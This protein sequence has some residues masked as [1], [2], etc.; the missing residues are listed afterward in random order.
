PPGSGDLAWLAIKNGFSSTDKATALYHDAKALDEGK[1]TPDRL[2]LDR[3]WPGFNYPLGVWEA[4]EKLR[5]ELDGLGLPCWRVWYQHVLSGHPE[6]KAWEQAFTDVP[7]R[8][9]WRKGPEAVNA[10]IS[11]RLNEIAKTWAA[12][13]DQSPAVASLPVPIEGVFSAVDF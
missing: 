13:R 2:A 7:G 11:E 6:G 5:S 10:V 4:W 9:P 1:V 8:L 12:T 3:L